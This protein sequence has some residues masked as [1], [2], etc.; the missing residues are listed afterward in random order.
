MFL[1]QNVSVLLRIIFIETVWDIKTEYRAQNVAI[2]PGQDMSQ[3]M[4]PILYTTT[5]F[6]V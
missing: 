6:L 3:N 1:D 5:L 2:A 4:C